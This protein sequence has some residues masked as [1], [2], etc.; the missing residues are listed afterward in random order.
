MPVQDNIEGYRLSPQQERLWSLQQ[1]G[2]AYCAQCTVVLEGALEVASLAASLRRVVARHEILRTNFRRA[3]G[4]KVPLQVLTEDVEPVLAALNLSGL[5]AAEQAA[6]VERLAR[7]ERGRSFDLASGCLL[8]CALVRLSSRRHM[9]LISLPALCADAA[10]L[11]NLTLEIAACY[12]A[13]EATDDTEETIQYAQF[14]AWQHE[15]LEE[16]G[17]EPGRAHWRA[18][19]PFAVPAV[20]LPLAKRTR[21]LAA[22]APESLSVSMTTDE[23]AHIHAAARALASE[24]GVLMLACWQTLIWRLTGQP[25]FAVGYNCDGRAHELLQPALGL[26]EKTVP[27]R[28]RFDA[29]YRFGEVLAW[30]ATATREA[31]EYQEYFTWPGANADEQ[32]AVYLPISF[33]FKEV[34]AKCEAAGLTFSLDGWYCCAERFDLKLSVGASGDALALAF[35]YDPAVYDAAH[36]RRIA[37]LFRTLLAA[38]LS[39]PDALLGELALLDD[40]SRRRLLHDFN[41]TATEYA[42]DQPLQLLFEAQAARTPDSAALVCEDQHLT[43][44]ELNARA[45]E[46][47]G[48]LR[49]LGVGPDA[50][51]GL[52]VERSVEMIVGLLGVLK[53]GGAYVPL[54]PKQ[55]RARLAAQL[56]DARLRVLLTQ[57]SLLDALPAYDGAVLCLDAAAAP[58]GQ[59]HNPV[60]VNAPQH[61]AYVIYTSGSTGEPKGVCVTHG[62]VANYTRALSERLKLDAAAQAPLSFATVSGIGADLG[63]TAIFLALATG[64]CLHV[65]GAALTTDAELFAAYLVERSIDVLKTVPSHLSALLSVA[66]RAL[67]RRHLILGGEAFPVSLLERIAETGGP[68]ELMNHY[69][70]TETTIGSLTFIPAQETGDATADGD[71]RRTS[72]TVPIGRPIANTRVYVLD[73]SLEPVPVGVGGELY[74]AG[75]G[76]ARGYLNRPALTAERFVPDPFGGA[77]GARMYRTGDQARHFAGACVEFCGRADNQ[78]K[79]RGFRVEPGE[80]EAT[81][82][83]HPSVRRAAVVAREDA[84]GLLRLVAYFVAEPAAT[85]ST[86]ELRRHVGES[87]PEYMTPSVFVQLP[88]LPLTLSGKIDRRALPDPAGVGI[89]PEAPYVPPET[90]V[91]QDV[92]RVWLEL[93]GVKRVGLDDNFF[94]LGGHSLLATQVI[95][96]LREVS[97]CELQLR[98]L[99]DRPT[100]GGLSET[101]ETMRWAAQPWQVTGSSDA[102]RREEGAL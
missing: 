92:A 79:V 5:S 29:G 46:L 34:S 2:A 102:P 19:E 3:P 10:T 4:L 60:C 45:N 22:F 50:L 42:L 86:G 94:E 64:G 13:V 87:L 57:S 18:R 84:N 40:A 28:R 1:D 91:Q 11:R 14:S 25:D 75:A 70:P 67:P 97:R 23:T 77:R 54:D 21:A 32:A 95:S 27:I 93:L 85:V 66:A 39:K 96:R 52:C 81:L 44:A 30:A 56:T 100:V 83:R 7:A 17:G 82:A 15:L 51:V 74:I 26:F 72:D 35:H 48:R 38:A 12:S 80:I 24:P 88:A 20:R 33:E 43:Y 47:A 58:D 63:N 36:V 78:I 69:G 6:S 73:Q 101:I 41:D 9:L 65:L 89:E 90:E 37:A 8:H 71:F 61:L 31:Y 98:H 16:E 99:F 55:P 59:T 62:A 68:C 76:L 53:A 49:R